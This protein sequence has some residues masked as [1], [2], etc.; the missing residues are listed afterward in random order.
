LLVS[1]K[2]GRKV[3]VEIKAEHE[4]RTLHNQAKFRAI[5][6]YA[7]ENRY[8]FE[9]WTSRWMIPAAWKDEVY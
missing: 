2:S 3:I 4:V 7:R 1:Y 8:D 9:V 5:K 6:E